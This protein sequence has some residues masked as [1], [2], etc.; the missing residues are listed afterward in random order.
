MHMFS[1]TDKIQLETEILLFLLC[2]V[3]KWK[4]QKPICDL[5]A[6]QYRTGTLMG[7]EGTG[8]VASGW[9]NGSIGGW[10]D[11]FVGGWMDG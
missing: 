10:M 1:D 5:C 7:L 4:L 9:M 2:N 6:C 3:G 11:G 8:Q